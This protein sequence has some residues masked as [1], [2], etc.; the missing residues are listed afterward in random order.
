MISGG[1][2]GTGGVGGSGEDG[3]TASGAGGAGG[4]GIIGSNLDIVNS[5]N[6]MGGSSGNGSQADAIQFTG[7]VNTLELH[8]GGNTSGP[9]DATAGTYNTLILGGT[10]EDASFNVSR[11]GGE[12]SFRY[13]GFN[14]FEKTGTGT[15]TL[16]SSTTELTPWTLSGGTLIISDDD[17]LGE[18]SGVLTFNGGTLETSSGFATSRAITLASAGTIRADLDSS[19]LELNGL[20]QGPGSLTLTGSG[21]VEIN[22]A[23]TYLGGTNVYTDVDVHTTGALGTG[24]VAVVGGM[25]G[26]PDDPILTFE[27][28]ASAGS[29][30][31]T[32][33]VSAVTGFADN[34]TAGNATITNTQG[35]VTAFYDTASAGAASIINQNIGSTAFAENASAGSATIT[36][37]EHG[38][39]LIMDQA[40]AAGAKVINQAGGIVDISYTDTGTSIG[41]LSGAGDVYLGG[42]P[43]TLGALGGND[44]IS[45][46]ISDGSLLADTDDTLGEVAHATGVTH[47]STQADKGGS[48]V[49][50]GSGTLIL[51]GANTYT[52]GTTVDAGTLAIGDADHLSASIKGDVQ[53]NAAGTLRGHGSIAGNVNNAGIVWPG[54][55]IG[56]LTIGGNYTQSPSGTLQMEISPT[57][58]SRLIVGG[59]ATLAGT[60][61]LLYAPGTYTAKSYSLVKA[62]SVQG[63]FSK[64]AGN[65][66][67]GFAQSVAYAADAVDLNLTGSG[68]VQPVVVAP[69][70]ATIFGA[71]GSSAL[72]AGQG[73]NE[74]LLDRLAGPCGVAAAGATSSGGAG[75]ASGDA[76]V[77]SLSCAR[78]GNGLWIQA[79]GT[80]TRID[81]NHG[82]P[83]ARDRRYGFLTGVDHQWQGWTVGV[84]GGYSHADISESGNGSKGTLDTLR[85]AGYGAKQFDA[86][87]LAGTLGY[88]Y[89]F[90]STTRSFGALGSARGD[91]HGQEFTAG[92]QASRPWSLGPVVLTPRLGVRYAY[93]DGLGT[94]ESGPTAQNLGVA[95][96]HLQSLQPYVGVTLDYPFTLHNN[97]RPASVQLRAGYAYETQS[98]GRDVSVTAVD[99]TG[100]VIAGTRD[101]R[102]LV[103][104]GLGATLP[105]GK[106]A[107]AYV[108]YDSVLHTG[109][110]NAQSLQAG[111]DYRF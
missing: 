26:G 54:G 71:M 5:G 107:S 86:Y 96:Q 84:A 87:T 43:L 1:S 19:P 9:V 16:L 14:A 99:G 101:T 102:G 70:Q 93:L 97:D 40:T 72:R 50:V 20:I 73:A 56:T 13:E 67:S 100:F 6:I 88:A 23:N 85:L 49:K 32:N 92:L 108:R 30:S 8:E 57:D 33:S 64:V 91:G 34:A 53:V 80:D 47:A 36:N 38:A 109:N 58:Y 81:G 68:P 4:V 41:S 2:G 106:S 44:T 75:A 78:Q 74:V 37:Q 35:G 45:G 69:T 11:I 95:N 46:V 31:I 77:Q 89:D 27:N 24:P 110:V 7:G 60:L 82:A 25:E 59:T 105:I 90:S 52:G 104:A 22:H 111:V 17:S 51:N 10:G 55:S 98:T 66:P 12:D 79:H 62:G 61:N 29:L 28:G 21:F 63:S 18:D 42:K 65:T 83:D 15:W 94:D 3:D 103:T 39:L 48:L 76:A